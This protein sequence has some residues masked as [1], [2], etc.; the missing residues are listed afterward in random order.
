[1]KWYNSFFLKKNLK[2]TK[3]KKKKKIKNRFIDRFLFINYQIK[4]FQ[5]LIIFIPKP[6]FSKILF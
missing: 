5:K 1:M 4:F 2:I 6:I 3:K